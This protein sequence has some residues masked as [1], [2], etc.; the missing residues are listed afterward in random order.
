[1][2]RAGRKP[3]GERAMSPAEKQ[4]RYRERLKERPDHK[5]AYF[6]LTGDVVNEI[7][8]LVSFFGLSSRS[9]LV[10]GFVRQGL[11]EALGALKRSEALG[12]ALPD[13]PGERESVIVKRGKF[14][15]QHWG[16]GN[17]A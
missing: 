16:N 8:A 5:Q 4:R 7:D 3:L 2:T 15:K 17:D 9:E 1:M 6:S 12:L 13:D 14:W 11:R 10:Q